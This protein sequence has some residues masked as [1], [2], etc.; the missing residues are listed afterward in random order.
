[1]K[2]KTLIDNIKESYKN[3]YKEYEYKKQLNGEM[4][5]LDKLGP[6]FGMDFDYDIPVFENDLIELVKEYGLQY[7]EDNCNLYQTFG[8]VENNPYFRSEIIE[9]Y[10]V[11]NLLQQKIVPNKDAGEF[12][13]VLNKFFEHFLNEFKPIGVKNIIIFKSKHCDGRERIN[14][15]ALLKY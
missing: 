7:T 2:N 13:P 11:D 12:R 8:I 3:S 9:Y 15:E 5:G 6:M 4:N 1:M 14:I 10:E